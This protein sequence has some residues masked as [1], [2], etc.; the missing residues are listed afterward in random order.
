MHT[1]REVARRGLSF[2]EVVQ[3]RRSVLERDEMRLKQ[4]TSAARRCSFFPHPTTFKG[5][6]GQTRKERRDARE[7]SI[8][9]YCEAGGSALLSFALRF[10]WLWLHP[11][12]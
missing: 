2:R 10:V 8:C 7:S 9:V 6:G 1:W 4:S 12:I 5:N 11:Q 3:K